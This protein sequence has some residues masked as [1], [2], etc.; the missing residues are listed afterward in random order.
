MIGAIDIGGTKIAVGI[1][2]RA[3]KVLVSSS[4][5]TQSSQGWRAATRT[6]VSMLHEQVRSTGAT[7]DGIGIGCT[8][9]VYPQQ[10]M[11]GNV[12]L[13][14]G[15]EA[16]PLSAEFA[17]AFGVK[18][19]LEN[20][21]DAAAIAESLWGSGRGVERFLYVTVSTGIGA[22]F[23]LYGRVYRGP[24]GAHPEMGHHVI[25]CA[26]PAC[27]CGS[28]GCFE[29]LASGT[30]LADW[31]AQNDL[32]GRRIPAQQVFELAAEADPTAIAAVA[33]FTRYLSIGLGNLVTILTPDV[34]AI[35]G[36]VAAQSSLFL[37]SVSEYMQRCYREVPVQAT[38]LCSA[39]LRGDVGL[40]GA[41]ATW[42]TRYG[43]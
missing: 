37:P 36:G 41:A 13:L 21:A 17:S 19:V 33:R 15:W 28:S 4:F 42:L 9:P 39:Q 11:V 22:G 12:A 25:D 27:A 8:G 30:A 18:V 38:L 34:I 43:G 16:C 20:D 14:P 5:P 6:A 29:S 1:V 31:F 23:L 35:G 40:A 32:L 26:G 10:G 2:D 24:N 7:L 3:G